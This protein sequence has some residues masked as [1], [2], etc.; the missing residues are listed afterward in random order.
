[1]EWIIEILVITVAI[2]IAGGIILGFMGTAKAAIP[3]RVASERCMWSTSIQQTWNDN[4]DTA[5]GMARDAAADAESGWYLGKIADSSINMFQ[6]EGYESTASQIIESASG[7]LEKGLHLA[8]DLCV[9]N[10]PVE[11]IGPADYVANCLYEYAVYG[12][13]SM[14]GG[15]GEI[16]AGE[17][18][19]DERYTGAKV[20]FSLFRITANVTHPSTIELEG[21]CENYLKAYLA[22]NPSYK[23]LKSGYFTDSNGKMI[24][25]FMSTKNDLTD[26]DC[27]YTMYQVGRYQIEMA[28][29]GQCQ[30]HY[31]YNQLYCKCFSNPDKGYSTLNGLPACDFKDEYG[32][33]EYSDNVGHIPGYKGCGCEQLADDYT[34]GTTTLSDRNIIFMPTSYDIIGGTL[35]P[36]N[37]QR[38]GPGEQKILYVWLHSTASMFV[39]LT[40]FEPS[41]D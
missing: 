5:I 25:R 8:V 21:P 20:N 23:N 7:D 33:V 30:K 39:F 26:G 14:G 37:Y 3:G 22:A 28:M 9:E 32:D 17:S 19:W 4:V 31:P 34:A 41:R 35:Y 24:D 27:N 11:C 6:G 18:D 36:Y 2:L 29:I 1:M 12:Y 16:N 10:T 13:Y 38:I 40:E 15:K